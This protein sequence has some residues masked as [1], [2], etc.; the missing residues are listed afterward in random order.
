MTTCPA[1]GLRLFP[2][3][4]PARPPASNAL[5]CTLAPTVATKT[6]STG[7]ATLFSPP[8]RPHS[9]IVLGP[10]ITPT[11]RN[12]FSNNEA[13]VVV[14]G[15]AESVSETDIY[16]AF[17]SVGQLFSV[18]LIRKGDGA[19]RGAFPP[20]ILPRIAPAPGPFLLTDTDVSP[21]ERR[22]RAL[23]IAFVNYRQIEAAVVAATVMNRALIDG[24][25]ISA[26]LARP[27]VTTT[28]GPY[29]ANGYLSS[30]VAGGLPGQAPV[31]STPMAPLPGY[32]TRP[33][34]PPVPPYGVG[35]PTTTSSYINPAAPPF[36]P[37]A[38]NNSVPA[39]DLGMAAYTH[40]HQFG[41]GAV[42]PHFAAGDPLARTASPQ[43]LVRPNA[44]LPPPS[45]VASF[46]NP[47]ATSAPVL[48]SVRMPQKT[49]RGRGGPGGGRGGSGRGR[50]RGRGRG[51][52]GARLSGC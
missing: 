48:Q 25:P 51:G 9:K 23:D 22:C 26:R 14:E 11:T 43:T 24:R 36:V 20:S 39:A 4:P 8:L 40:N 17:A 6:T 5:C 37:R 3:R 31:P 38:F 27:R 2:I 44:L 42:P 45:N 18:N 15:I 16:D 13:T 10:G 30:V 29:G 12:I 35:L 52:G 7:P 47:A 41:G 33:P 21:G 19:V 50:G 1:V 32:A 34:L 46:L 28:S 49:R